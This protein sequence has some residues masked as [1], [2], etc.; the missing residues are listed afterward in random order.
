M[1][2]AAPSRFA[3]ERGEVLELVEAGRL[4]PDLERARSSR[5]TSCRAAAACGTSGSSCV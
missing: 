2:I 5:L 4:N 1:I 3:V